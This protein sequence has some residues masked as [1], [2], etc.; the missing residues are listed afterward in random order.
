[1]R[2]RL[3]DRWSLPV[4]WTTVWCLIA[5]CT[6]EPGALHL[7]LAMNKTSYRPDEQI[8]LVATLKTTDK[9]IILSKQLV[10]Q[11]EM[12]KVGD[13]TVYIRK[14]QGVFCG[15]GALFLMICPWVIPIAWMDVADLQQHFDVMNPNDFRSREL[16]LSA[17]ESQG[18][19]YISD[20][21][22]AHHLELAPGTYQLTVTLDN[23]YEPGIVPPLFWKPYDQPVS[24]TIPI[25][26]V[27]G[28]TS[29]P[30]T[31]PER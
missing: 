20:C 2:S 28:T 7:S 1:M 3:I 19:A 22:F 4:S 14:E 18:K 16:S 15:M 30:T 24:A 12:T 21:S 23:R 25:T 5:G 8:G 27:P 17:Y 13:P 29:G 26:I 6:N 31:Q 11:A 10:F 9:P